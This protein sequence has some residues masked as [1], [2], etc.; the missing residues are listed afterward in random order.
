M[1]QFKIKPTHRNHGIYKEV[2]WTLYEK[3]FGLFWAKI[4]ESTNSLMVREMKNHL[5]LPT[6]Y[7]SANNNPQE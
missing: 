3:R 2:T 6:K 7:Y 5:F 1:K 4:F